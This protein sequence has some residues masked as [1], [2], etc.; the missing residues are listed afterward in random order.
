[1]SR[2]S[3]VSIIV[4]G[5]NAAARL[6]ATVRS[7]SELEC[8]R[9]VSMEFLYIDNRST[10]DSVEVV[11]R[12]WEASGGLSRFGP[13]RIFHEATPGSTF[14]RRTGVKH[15]V[16]DVV[17]FVDDDNSLHEDYVV[18]GLSLFEELPEL[19]ACG[20]VGIAVSS[21]PLPVWFPRFQSL[22][23]CGDDGIGFRTALPTAGLMIRRRALEDL[24]AVGFEP[25]L[26]GRVGANTMA[27]EDSELTSALCLTGWRIWKDP[28]LRF[29]HCLESRRLS[30]QYCLQLINGL[31]RSNVFVC[32]YARWVAHDQGRSV[33]RLWIPWLPT[34]VAQVVFYSVAAYR[35]RRKAFLSQ[36]RRATVLGTRDGAA[37]GLRL[38]RFR[39]LRQSIRRLR[40]RIRRSHKSENGRFINGGA[41]ECRT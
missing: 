4:V 24:H 23:A 11:K 39:N 6:P 41:L 14:A 19:G 1:M 7:L 10:D 27:G 28:D 37:I 2:I 29:D 18:R 12:E 16:G 30:E 33:P 40:E 8:P 36:C 35:P 3:G 26:E 13:W 25:V 5:F 9:D 22:Y 38:G 32:E 21:V 31:A 20:G 15:A 17:L 34:L